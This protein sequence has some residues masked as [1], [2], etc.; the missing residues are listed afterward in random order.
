M[1]LWLSLWQS[2]M[3]W[4]AMNLANESTTLHQSIWSE[5]QPLQIY[6]PKVRREEIKYESMNTVAGAFLSALGTKWV[7]VALQLKVIAVCRYRYSIYRYV[8]VQFEPFVCIYH[9]IADQY[10]T[11]NEGAFQFCCKEGLSG[12]FSDHSFSLLRLRSLPLGSGW[13]CL[14][15]S[16]SKPSSKLFLSPLDLLC[17]MFCG[18]PPLAPKA[19]P[20][21]S[22]TVEGQDGFSLSL[23][24]FFT[25]SLCC[26]SSFNSRCRCGSLACPLKEDTG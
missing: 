13:S 2:R 19:Q 26:S 17:I 14:S 7:G 10:L 9:T 6:Q 3:N 24:F 22:C 21:T 20:H 12:L 18:S 1:T 23:A 15:S 5:H 11:K 25:L 4:S 8:H 16:P